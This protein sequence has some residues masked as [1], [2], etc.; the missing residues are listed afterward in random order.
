[1]ADITPDILFTRNQLAEHVNRIDTE[2]S[3]ITTQNVATQAQL[4]TVA[5]DLNTVETF[6]T[7]HTDD[8][9][10][11]TVL[12]NTNTTN[13][14]SNDSDIAGI[15]TNIDTIKTAL[16]NNGASNQTQVDAIQVSVNAH[17]D[18]ITDLAALINTNTTNIQSNDTDIAGILTNIDTI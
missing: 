11:M 17:T 9:A 2:I 7:G 4:D 5:T 13:I 12:I 3:A 1:L 10:A 16:T 15:L 18:D 6:I 14:T 8:I